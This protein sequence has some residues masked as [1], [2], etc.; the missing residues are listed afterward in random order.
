MFDDL[1]L[2]IEK[3]KKNANPKSNKRFIVKNKKMH[4]PSYE[5]LAIYKFKS[6]FTK[7]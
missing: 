1:G 4:S 6:I 3:K 5:F 7:V 2:K